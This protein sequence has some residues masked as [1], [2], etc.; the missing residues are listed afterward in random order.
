[1]SNLVNVHATYRMFTCSEPLGDIQL[2]SRWVDLRVGGDFNTFISPALIVTAYIP[3]PSGQ[4]LAQ[5]EHEQGPE[6]Y[7][8]YGSDLGIHGCLVARE[9]RAVLRGEVVGESASAFLYNLYWYVLHK[10]PAF[11][12]WIGKYATQGYIELLRREFPNET[13][14]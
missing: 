13:F 7:L 3:T 2:D 10:D 12:G 11:R 4:K 6:V 5:W 9:V 8:N 14:Q 1:M